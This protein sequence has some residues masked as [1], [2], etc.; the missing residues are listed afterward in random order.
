M[1]AIAARRDRVQSDGWVL[2]PDRPAMIDALKAREIPTAVHYPVCL[3]QQPVY[4]SGK[5][6]YVAHD[7]PYAEYASA[8]VMSLPMYPGIEPELQQFIVDAMVA[9]L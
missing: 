4:Q 9:A 8:H 2:V 3:H 7:V 1:Q 6:P 5:A